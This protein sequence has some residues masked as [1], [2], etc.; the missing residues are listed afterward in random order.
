M[1]LYDS[2]YDTAGTGSGRRN[3]KTELI[4]LSRA[5]KTETTE[6]KKQNGK[7]EGL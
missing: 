1:Y 4:G 2:V 7:G 3:R 6:K 5:M